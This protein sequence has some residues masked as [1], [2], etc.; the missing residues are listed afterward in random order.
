MAIAPE[1]GVDLYRKSEE[2]SG[3]VDFGLMSANISNALLNESEEPELLV[4]VANAAEIPD[5]GIV[6]LLEQLSRSEDIKTLR[7][8][9]FLIP[10]AIR[11]GLNTNL[12]QQ[13]LDCLRD[14]WEK[15]TKHTQEQVAY[16]AQEEFFLSM[17]EIAVNDA[18][19]YRKLAPTLNFEWFD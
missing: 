8:A 2:Q 6:S 13:D 3:E 19:T 18:D 15:L 14:A 4:F 12:S 10:K 11:S 7:F 5:S 17:A 16:D 9:V 1:A